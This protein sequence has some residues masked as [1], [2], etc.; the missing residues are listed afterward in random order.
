MYLVANNVLKL[1]LGGHAGWK[2]LNTP[3]RDHMGTQLTGLLKRFSVPY[4]KL[5]DSITSAIWEQIRCQPHS[6]LLMQNNI[7][8]YLNPTTHFTY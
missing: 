2:G 8:W 6:T 4:W 3:L 1:F 5:K 7:A